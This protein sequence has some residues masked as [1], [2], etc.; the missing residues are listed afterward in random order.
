MSRILAAAS[1]SALKNS[2]PT[3][4]TRRRAWRRK[5]AAARSSG[6]FRSMVILS[7]K[8]LPFAEV[9]DFGA[10]NFCLIERGSGAL[11]GAG[12]DCLC[13]RYARYAKH[14]NREKHT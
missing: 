3:P 6:S 14:V 10:E 13:I 8:A 2:E 5:L 9:V 11:R 4:L 1:L 7:G 12:L